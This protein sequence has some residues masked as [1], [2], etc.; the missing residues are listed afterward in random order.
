M[1]VRHKQC[2]KTEKINHFSVVS[3]VLAAKAAEN[4]EMSLIPFQLRLLAHSFCE[5]LKLKIETEA[6]SSV[7]NTVL[8]AKAEASEDT[9][10]IMFH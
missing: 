5:K 6:H 4:R 10:H 9:S 7:V 3:A 8:V 1:M 2:T